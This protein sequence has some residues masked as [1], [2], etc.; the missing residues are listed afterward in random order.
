MPIGQAT[1]DYAGM[2]VSA[3]GAAAHTVSQ[4]DK[5]KRKK[6]KGDASSAAIG[7]ALV[8]SA[9]GEG[10]GQLDFNTAAE[11]TA[12]VGG[13]IK[14]GAAKGIGTGGMSAPKAQPTFTATASTP[15]GLPSTAAPAAPT[16]A[17][18]K[19]GMGRAGWGAVMGAGLGIMTHY[20]DE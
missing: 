14:E 11:Q 20:L 2:S 9:V 12:P 6:P 18:S 7:G 3:Q 13:S 5:K 4:M 19:P 16:P 8:G 15:A 10:M 17:T 1:R